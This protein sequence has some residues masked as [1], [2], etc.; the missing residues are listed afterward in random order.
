MTPIKASES[1]NRTCLR[2]THILDALIVYLNQ[3]YPFLSSTGLL[4]KSYGVYVGCS[5]PAGMARTFLHQLEN[6]F[7]LHKTIVHSGEITKA[8]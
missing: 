2:V 5:E 8:D 4:I 3:H 6:V 1:P 7:F